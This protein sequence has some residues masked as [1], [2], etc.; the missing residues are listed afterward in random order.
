MLNL[1]RRDTT[2]FEYVSVDHV[3]DI[4]Q[5]YMVI[6]SVRSSGPCLSSVV[7]LERS[8]SYFPP[9]FM[10]KTKENRPH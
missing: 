10:T 7:L 3:S 8:Q 5:Y 1:H 4:F 9:S 2:E 6:N